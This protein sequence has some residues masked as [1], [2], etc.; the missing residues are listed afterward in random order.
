MTIKLKPKKVLDT[1]RDPAYLE[2]KMFSEMYED[3]PDGAFFALAEDMHGWDVADWAWYSE[4]QSKDPD[5][6]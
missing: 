6:N 1:I 3:M 2:M 5:F 4:L